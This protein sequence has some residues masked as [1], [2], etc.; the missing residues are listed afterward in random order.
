M[1]QLLAKNWWALE[2]RGALTIVFGLLAL[3]MPAI[4]LGALVLLFGIYALVEGI[5]LLAMSF[6]RQNTA[7]VDHA[8][9]GACRRRCRYRYIRL[10]GN[11]SCCPACHHRSLGAYNG[12][13]R[14]CGSDPASEGDPRRM[15]ADFERRS[16]AGLCLYSP[17]ESCGGRIG[18]CHRDR[19]IRRYIWHSPHG[20]G[21]QNP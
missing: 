20:P 1:I 4:T 3:F 11:H 13:S 14:D 19:H 16:L 15:A 6:N 5:V 2:L 12:H 21:L 7:L 9:P 8:A 17:F 18:A 10:A